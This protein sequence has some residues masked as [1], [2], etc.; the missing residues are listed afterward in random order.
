[1]YSLLQ[2]GTALMIFDSVVQLKHGAFSLTQFMTLAY[3][4]C[5]PPKLLRRFDWLEDQD[6]ARS[7]ERQ[8]PDPFPGR[9]GC[10][11]FRDGASELQPQERRFFFHT[12]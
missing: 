4:S 2:D 1:M 10:Q 6:G 9:W 7:P 12:R 8:L 11:L 3:Y 5:I